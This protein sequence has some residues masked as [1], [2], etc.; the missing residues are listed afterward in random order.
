MS[1]GCS[2]V[3]GRDPALDPPVAQHRQLRA[4]VAALDR[5]HGIHQPQALEGVAGV[6]D[7]AVEQLGEVLLDV[8]PRQGRAAEHDRPAL[9]HPAL[10]ELL[11]VL[12][13]DHGALDQQAGHAD[14]V[15]VVLVGRVEDGVDRLLDAE[16]DDGVAVVGQDD[17]DEVLA[18]VV[19]VALDRG[20]HDRALA[21]V[22]GLLHVRLEVGDGGLHH[23]GRLQHERQL[24]LAGAEQLADHLHPGQQVVVDDVERG[25]ARCRAP[26][27][28]RLRGRSSRRR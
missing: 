10:V 15:G 2:T 13:H 28:G 12:L 14:H 1:L 4:R 9:G 22:V 3:A 17:V 7:L 26:R 19:H 21:A 5:H 23:L 25:A 6:A 20:E 27:R 24:H 11:E 18:D 16:V 8:R